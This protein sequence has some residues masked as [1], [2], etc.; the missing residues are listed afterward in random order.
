MEHELGQSPI[1]GK[2]VNGTTNPIPQVTKMDVN[3]FPDSVISIIGLD[4]PAQPMKH[5]NP[6]LVYQPEDDLPF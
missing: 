6:E 2:P 4:D 5:L 1:N 3:D